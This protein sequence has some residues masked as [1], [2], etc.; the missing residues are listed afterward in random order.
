MTYFVLQTVKDILGFTDTNNDTL[1]NDLGAQADDHINDRLHEFYVILPIA[2]P[3]AAIIDAANNF[4]IGRYFK[5]TGQID[6][7]KVFWD[8]GEMEISVFIHSALQKK[9]ATFV[10]QY[11]I[12]TT[13]NFFR[14][15]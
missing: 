1:L 15:P 4:T 9:E 13:G 8:Y 12:N 5:E 2:S 14:N 10:P 11:F 7:G 3:D 6:R